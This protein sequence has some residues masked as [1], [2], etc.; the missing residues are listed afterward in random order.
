[1]TLSISAPMPLIEFDLG[2]PCW[3]QQ[4]D[5][6]RRVVDVALDARS[7]QIHL[8]SG[9][10]DQL[11]GLLE[12]RGVGRR[13]AVISDEHVAH[14]HLVAVTDRLATAGYRV[15]TT[16]LAPGEASKNFSTVA[17][18]AAR[19]LDQGIERRD[20]IIALGGGVIG[21]IAGFAASILR[22][23]VPYVQIPTSLLAMVD[24]AV[25]GK[26][27]ID[28]AAGKNLVGSFYQ[29]IGVIADLDLLA[30]LPDRELRAGYAEIVKYGVIADAAFF[31][32]LEREGGAAL[33]RR[34]RTAQNLVVARSLEIKAL[35][36]AADEHESGARALLNFGHTYGHALEAAFGYG[37]GLRHGEAVSIGMVFAMRLSRDLG[38]CAG[39]SVAR[40]EAHLQTVGLPVRCSD[41]GASAPDEGVIMAAM[42]QDKKVR[43]GLLTFILA[44][45]IG[46]SGVC[47]AI[48]EDVLLA[49]LA[50]AGLR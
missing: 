24:S 33:M 46:D 4:A 34:D 15:A 38:L 50:D 16:I 39:A 22:R 37:D 23:G 18:L 42:R 25:G 48:P 45:D 13:L 2:L 8:G 11:A 40:L 17:D 27:G 44:R 43:D 29:P 21:D 3:H 12:Q 30:T 47:S 36:V 5:A 35:I 14:H 19:L 1:M 10:L 20:A 28:M 41:L 31:A 7:Y 26:T 32:W 49:C 6:D 9:A